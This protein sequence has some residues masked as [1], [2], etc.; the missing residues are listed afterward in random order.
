MIS[1][2]F[3][4]LAL[5][6][7]TAGCSSLGGAALDAGNAYRASRNPPDFRKAVL[8]PAFSYLE[9]R[10]ANN[11]ALMVLAEVDTA[12]GSG[13]VVETW[14][15]GSK[16]VLR[17]RNGFVVASEGVPSLPQQV[18]LHTDEQGDPLALQLTQPELGAYGVPIP[19]QRVSGQLIQLPR[20]EL[21][22]RAQQVKD[23]RLRAWV[24]QQAASA[25]PPRAQPFSEGVYLVGTHP[26]TGRLVYGYH[27]HRKNSCLEYLVRTAADNL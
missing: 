4:W 13:Q 10:V 9:V 15:S 20:L 23:L 16:E 6:M 25:T 26:Q 12:E 2:I 7:L 1:R 5:V 21:L 14:V 27:C 3:L 24:P 19:L 22:A 18:E 11:S 17:L 8:N